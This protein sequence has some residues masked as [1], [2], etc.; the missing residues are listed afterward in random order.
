[1]PLFDT[2]PKGLGLYGIAALLAVVELGVFW[3]TLHPQVSDDYR[4]YYITRASTCLPQPVTAAYKVG[5]LVD[6]TNAGDINAA[7][8]LLPCG[9]ESP[10][11]DGRQSLGETSRMRFTIGAPQALELELVLKGINLND[12]GP[13]QVQLYAGELFVGEIFV[14]PEGTDTYTLSIPA[15]AITDGL[16]E[17]RLEFPNAIET[18]PGIANIYWR[19]V[20]LISARL[21]PA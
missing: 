6:F 8:E 12:A 19:S 13:R 2:T 3:Q 17:L 14:D 21:S 20:K 4:A 15:E 1:M 5:E 11:D 10:N 9:W 16:L 7:R 18:S